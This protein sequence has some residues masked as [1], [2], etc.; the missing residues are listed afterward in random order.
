MPGHR[1]SIAIDPGAQQ[2]FPTVGFVL[3]G[4][5]IVSI[6]PQGLLL[7]GQVS[8]KQHTPVIVAPPATRCCWPLSS[9]VI[10]CFCSI[11]FR[12]RLRLLFFIWI[13]FL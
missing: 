7:A 5:A 10:V 9:V 6:Q 3:G 4:Q 12:A 1:E 8:V 2:G 11:S 13:W